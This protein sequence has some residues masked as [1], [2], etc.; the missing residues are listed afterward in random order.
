MYEREQIISFLWK[1]LSIIYSYHTFCRA[2]VA[3]LKL[4]NGI[5]YTHIHT[6]AICMKKIIFNDVILIQTK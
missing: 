4:F 1:N 2:I 3:K 6:I 5:L